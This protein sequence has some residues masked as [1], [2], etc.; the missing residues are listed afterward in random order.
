V[1]VDG[2]RSRRGVILPA[3]LLLLLGGTLVAA[4]LLVVARSAVLLADG[5]RGLAEALVRRAPPLALEGSGTEILPVG[6]GFVVLGA[7]AEGVE[8]GTWRVVWQADPERIAVGLRAVVES[9]A[10][11]VEG[12]TGVSAASLED[13]CPD[14][15]PL[16]PQST[17]VSPSPPD[18]IPRLPPFPRIGPVGLEALVARAGEP[19]PGGTEL[20]PSHGTMTAAPGA[21]IDD[22]SAAGILVVPGDL[23]LAGSARFEGLLLLAGDLHV[24][25]EAR[26]HGAVRAAGAVR[27][28]TEA[29]ILGCR[30]LVHERLMGL[31]ALAHPFHVPGGRFLGRH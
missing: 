13:G 25:D 30:A 9:G 20:P 24:E 4:S 8:W 1:A 29:R 12:S 18:P 27:L 10:G 11:I 21:R 31:E 23:T 19:L 7:R 16:P 22:G 26:I 28:G 17:P 5:D 15:D 14:L 6:D 3:A 2:E